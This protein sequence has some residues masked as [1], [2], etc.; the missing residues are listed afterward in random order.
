VTPATTILLMS[1]DEGEMLAYSLPAATL[2]HDAEVV[3][4]DNASS[5]TTAALVREHG[6][7][8][9]RI[10][11]RRS[12]AVAMNMALAEAR[13]PSVLLLNADCFLAPDFLA[14]ARPHL[15]ADGV[16]S[17]APKL[18]RTRGPLD[19]GPPMGID[20]AGMVVDRRRKNG[21]VG[22]GRPAA[23][24]GAAADCFG[25]DGAAALYRR[26][27]LARCALPPRDG[28]AYSG[29]P[30]ILDEDM[31]LWASDADLAWRARLF[32][33]RCV[34][35][36]AAVARHIRTYSPSTRHQVAEAH[37]RL[38]F[39]N[40][41]VMWAKNETREDLLRDL[42]RIATYEL[43][44]LGHAVLRERHLLQG[45]RDV[46]AALPAARER[47]REVQARRAVSRVPFGLQAPE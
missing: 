22:H 23:A 36:P 17:V 25:A 44:A 5:D 18:L 38:Q 26:D 41:Y 43:A 24:F 47:R 30:E 28:E 4:V 34:Y 16:G 8:H 11:H 3:V 46:R 39:R 33:Y 27:V 31:A 20:A 9:L 12:Y 37:R 15:D 1:V 40:R 13:T 10:R 19:D 35:E 2:Q 6:A 21:L 45:Y 32:G 7:G 29:L 42:P 14:R